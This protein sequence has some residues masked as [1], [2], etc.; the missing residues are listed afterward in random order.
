M[1][2]TSCAEQLLD[3]IVASQTDLYAESAAIT[4]AQYIAAHEAKLPPIDLPKATRSNRAFSRF[5]GW[6]RQM[7][8]IVRY[9]AFKTPAP[10]EVQFALAIARWQ[11]RQPGLKVDGMLGRLTWQ[12]MKGAIGP[13]PRIDLARA[14]KA[15]HSLAN[16]LGWK[17]YRSRIS[18]LIGFLGTV[19]ND[20]DFAQAVARWQKKIGRL[21]VDGILG[22]A[23]LKRMS[24]LLLP[25]PSVG[26]KAVSRFENNGPADVFVT[27]FPPPLD[28]VTDEGH[29]IIT[30]AAAHRAGFPARPASV[31]QVIAGVKRVD[32]G[33]RL[34]NV[35]KD[36]AHALVPDMQR[37]HALRRRLCT[38][39]APAIAEIRSEL[40]ALHRR[41]VR[42]RRTSAAMGFIG[43]ALHLIQDAY[44]AAHMERTPRKM[45]GGK[46]QY[47]RFYAIARLGWPPIE[48]GTGPH[49]HG[50]PLD[51][52]D[53][54]HTP[55]GALTH[56]SRQAIDASTDYLQLMR[57]LLAGGRR[58]R[59]RTIRRF[60]NKHLSL[61]STLSQP[62][63]FHRRCRP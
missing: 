17:V 11:S 34:R 18:R 27:Q 61:S 37:K 39:M 47:I 51:P 14:R 60:M 1:Q 13:F 53:N 35:P 15:N 24:P 23:T 33:P 6:G 38:T 44:S 29:E 42:A 9:L 25:Q 49:E 10:G 41:A 46:I 22:P 4:P 31:N 50:F 3:R 30:R 7:A 5:L 59:I 20:T 2:R 8:D 48:I 16:S 21:A 36:L 57:H 55:G 43:E 56:E 45:S 58:P 28:R 12:R 63:H 32:V 62:D 52:L 54:I 26:A 40:R 19:P